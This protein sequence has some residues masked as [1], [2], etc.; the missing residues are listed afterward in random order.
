[1]GIFDFLKPAAPSGFSQPDWRQSAEECLGG[2]EVACEFVTINE[3]D[4]PSNFIGAHRP[5]TP[6]A[7]VRAAAHLAVPLAAVKAVTEVEALGAGF[8][9]SG[10]PKILFESHLFARHTGGKYSKSHPNLSTSKWD[11]TTYGAGGEHQYTRLSKAIKLN[12]SAALKSASWGA[13]QILGGNHASCGMPSVESF[14]Q[15][16]CQGEDE[17]LT[18]FCNFVTASKSMHAALKRLD[19][20]AFAK[21]YNGPQQHLNSYDKRLSKA[22]AKHGG[23]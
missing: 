6:A 19:W 16:M 2:A 9:A 10:R 21:A 17:Q 14:V 13:F 8:L 1:M 3:P 18:L 4:L 11:R 23:K 5:L 22:Y 12:R 20:T 7:Q 15:V